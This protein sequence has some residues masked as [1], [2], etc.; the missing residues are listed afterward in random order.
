MP[1]K[2]VRGTDP[3]ALEAYGAAHILV[4]PDLFVA[5]AGEDG[6]PASVLARATGHG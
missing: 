1:L 6:D 4:R 3:A 2:L 5:W